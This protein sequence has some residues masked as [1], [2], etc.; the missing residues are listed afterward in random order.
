MVDLGEGEEVLGSFM[1]LLFW[2]G[3]SITCDNRLNGSIR[4]PHTDYFA[5]NVGGHILVSSIRQIVVVAHL[6]M[7]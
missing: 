3:S 6:R 4:S 2:V 7:P 5:L 1:E